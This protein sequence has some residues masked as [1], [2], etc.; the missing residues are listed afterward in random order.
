MFT[1]RLHRFR[2]STKFATRPF[3][4]QRHPVVETRESRRAKKSQKSRLWR[5]IADPIA[6]RPA[7]SGLPTYAAAGVVLTGFPFALFSAMLS[8][9]PVWTNP[10]ADLRYYVGALPLLLIM[11]G[12]IVE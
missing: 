1:R 4:W 2:I 5:S 10:I 6:Q 9:Q 12:L 7:G 8:V 11:K 3:L